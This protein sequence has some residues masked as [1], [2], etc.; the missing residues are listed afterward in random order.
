M[1][2]VTNQQKEFLKGISYAVLSAGK[3]SGVWS[4]ETAPKPEELAHASLGKHSE[5][6]AHYL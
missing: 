6:N 4:D 1:R 5:S 3:T 2:I